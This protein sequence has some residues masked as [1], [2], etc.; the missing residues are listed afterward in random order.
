M[1]K[2]HGKE[3]MEF[4]HGGVVHATNGAQVIAPSAK[5]RRETHLFANTKQLN[6]SADTMPRN[7]KNST[8]D[9]NSKDAEGHP[10]SIT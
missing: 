1:W 9:L 5:M 10:T 8:K 2:F 4:Q 3:T 7:L 6:A